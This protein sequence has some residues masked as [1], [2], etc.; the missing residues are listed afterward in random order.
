MSNVICKCPGCGN[1]H[2]SKAAADSGRLLNNLLARIHRDGGHHTARVGVEKAAKSADVI[3]SHAIAVI[4]GLAK[5]HN[6]SMQH[7]PLSASKN[8][9]D[10]ELASLMSARNAIYNDNSCPGCGELV[11]IDDN[12]FDG[13]VVT[14]P[15]CDKCSTW[16]SFDDGTFQLIEAGEEDDD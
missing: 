14:C 10:L 15:G 6:S 1:V 11:D 8:N 16:T 13:A 7:G 2:G 12:D 9:L 3:V 4:D 5:Y